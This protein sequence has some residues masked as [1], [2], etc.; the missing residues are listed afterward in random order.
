[1]TG[2]RIASCTFRPFRAADSASSKKARRWNSKSARARKDHKLRTSWPSMVALVVAAVV[3]AVVVVAVAAGA[4]T[5]EVVVEAEVVA[6]AETVEIAAGVE[7]VR[8]EERR[9]GKE[10][11][12]GWVGEDYNK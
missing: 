12:C 8:S 5:A 4:A 2:A 9:V 1:M 6:A 7:D 11:R 10:W 3:V